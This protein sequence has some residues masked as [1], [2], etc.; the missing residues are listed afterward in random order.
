MIPAHRLSFEPW[1]MLRMRL[2]RSIYPS[3]RQ[4][5]R[6]HSPSFLLWVL[7]IAHD[8]QFGTIC[9]MYT[10]FTPSFRSDFFESYSFSDDPVA[11]VQCSFPV[12]SLQ[13]VL[14]SLRTVQ[15][16]RMSFE[17]HRSSHFMAI[18]MECKHG[19]SRTH[20][21]TYEPCAIV[22]ASFD[23]TKAPHWW[24]TDWI[25]CYGS[26]YYTNLLIDGC[27]SSVP[28]TMCMHWSSWLQ[29]RDRSH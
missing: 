18:R 23:R 25:F 19:V 5:L 7:W 1:A 27:T 6:G 24:E 14:R 28:P 11:S 2:G 9:S 26:Q 16:A 13:A 21:F 20:S 10:W 3:V 12:K 17:R 8:P 15:R 22:H 29:Y 4:F